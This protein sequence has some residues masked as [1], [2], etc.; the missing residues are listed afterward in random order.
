MKLS[1]LEKQVNKAFRR[2]LQLQTKQAMVRHFLLVKQL[3]N[4]K[5]A[6]K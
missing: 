1:K 5:P 6:H 3:D 2:M 4:A